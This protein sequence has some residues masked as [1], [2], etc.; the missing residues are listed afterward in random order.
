MA[1]IAHKAGLQKSSLFHHF[2]TKDQL[3]REVLDG[4]L[5]EVTTT[6]AAAITTPVGGFLERL[7]ASSMAAARSLGEDSSRARLI[8]REL[9]NEDGDQHHVESVVMVIDATC[10]FLE[11]GVE[12][13]A[14]PRQDFKQVVLTMAGIHC[15]YFAVPNITRRV[16]GGDPFTTDAVEHRV[17]AVRLQVRHMLAI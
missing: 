7:D 14:W 11:E 2:P 5:H 9:L 15:F 12:A 6:V 3:Y 10:Q 1:D 17:Q 16:N 8:M 13:G 4:V